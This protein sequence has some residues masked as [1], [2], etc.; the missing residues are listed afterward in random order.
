VDNKRY[1]SGNKVLHN[2]VG[3][4][5]GVFVGN[6]GDL[7]TGLPMQ[8]LHDGKQWVHQP[9]RLNVFIDAPMEAIDAIIQKHE[10][11][12]N[13]VVNEWIHLYRLGEGDKPVMK[14]GGDGVV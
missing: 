6:G 1:G 12:R 14:Y 7:R 3:G 2:V 9:V 8:S 11:V 4:T 10:V 13:L 5:I